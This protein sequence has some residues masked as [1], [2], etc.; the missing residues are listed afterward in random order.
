MDRKLKSEI[1]R[2]EATQGKLRESIDEARRLA[3]QA[4]SLLQNHKRN[5]RDQGS[6]AA[7]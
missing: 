6:Q 1:A 2:I 7:G 3:Q 4:D 5:L